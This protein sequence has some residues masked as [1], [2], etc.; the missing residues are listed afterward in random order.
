MLI[1]VLIPFI[2]AE[3]YL[4]LSV[5]DELG[6]GLSVVWII[7]SIFLGITLLKNSQYTIATGFENVANG[8]LDLQKFQNASMA[9]VFGSI[10]ILVPGILT[11]TL[12]VFLML[13]TIYLH[14]IAK[15][16]PP[17]QQQTEQQDKNL[18]NKK[19]ENDVIDVE[20][21]D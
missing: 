8:K 9:Y 18:N 1:V 3:L 5:V 10:F 16:T 4:S 14:T 11:D 2:L 13:Y 21:I 19:G 17:Q 20:I 6:A 15:L 12:G 7:G